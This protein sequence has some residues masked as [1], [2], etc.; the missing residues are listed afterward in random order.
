MILLL[1]GQIR[2][3]KAGRFMRGWEEREWLLH[4]GKE[5]AVTGNGPSSHAPAS[6]KEIVA[7]RLRVQNP[8]ALKK[9]DEGGRKGRT[10][11]QSQ[12][13]PLREE[14]TSG[15]GLVSMLASGEHK[16]QNWV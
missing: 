4:R 13:K 11:M 14:V 8:E 15:R 1:A 3:K 16:N 12:K 10:D 9:T 5:G 2:K 7:E 6:M